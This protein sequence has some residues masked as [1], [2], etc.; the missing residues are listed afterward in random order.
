[1]LNRQESYTSIEEARKRK[2]KIDWKTS[3]ICQ[4]PNHLG[5][6]EIGCI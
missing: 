4:A 1:M 2:F 6:Q 3:K 5:V